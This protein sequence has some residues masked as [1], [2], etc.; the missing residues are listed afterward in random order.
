MMKP[1]SAA[2]RVWRLERSVE[3]S[4]EIWPSLVTCGV[5]SSLMPVSRNWTFALVTVVA[6][7]APDATSTTRTGMSSPTRIVA[8]LLSWVTMLGSAW[9]SERL[10]CSR[11]WRKPVTE[12]P[13]MT[14]EK[15]RSSAG[16]VIV[17]SAFPMA[18]S[19]LPPRFTMVRTGAY[20]CL[21]CRGP[22]EDPV[23]GRVP[24]PDVVLEAE[25]LQIGPVHE[26]DLGLDRDHLGPEVEQ[27][28]EFDGRFE[29][30]LGVGEDDRVAG[31]VRRGDTPLAEHALERS[32]HLAHPGIVHP[33]D[34][35]FAGLERVNLG[36]VLGGV[37]PEDPAGQL[38]DREP[39][40]R[41]DGVERLGPR[42]VADLRGDRAGDA[43]AE[44]DGAAADRLESGNDFINAGVD[45]AD[46]DARN[47][48]A[49]DP[50]HRAGGLGH[51]L[52]GSRRQPRR[53]RR[54]DRC[55]RRGLG[56]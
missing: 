11:A 8:A 44:D 27:V 49:L 4:S 38:L 21:P 16:D 5:T 56:P 30:A 23:I 35:G 53:G 22:G 31:G 42:L 29:V 12:K 47:L 55:R 24:G 1:R 34:P 3:R 46:R 10:T 52:G 17:A 14:V 26:D 13:P 54:L 28:H 45:P 33:H 6:E 32:S 40:G 25:L 51:V 48:A 9:T 18:A 43:L 39:L 50:D 2:A 37:H 36:E 19:S 15:T 20:G 41:E 7:A